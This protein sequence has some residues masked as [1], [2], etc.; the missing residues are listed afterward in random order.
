MWAPVG[1]FKGARRRTARCGQAARRATRAKARHPGSSTKAGRADRAVAA[2][3]ADRAAPPPFLQPGAR[4]M[5]SQ[6]SR[7][8]PRA[9]AGRATFEPL[10][11]RRLLSS[12]WTIDGTDA[13]DT[14]RIRQSGSTV[15]VTRNGVTARR[16]D[17][18]AVTVNGRGGND[19]IV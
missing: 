1:P 17:V 16:G 3:R 6:G 2:T 5:S 4:V 18:S 13:A 7:P 9:R 8:I 11:G 12:T 10:E 14:I 19:T 15:S